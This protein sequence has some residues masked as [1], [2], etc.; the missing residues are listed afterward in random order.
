MSWQLEAW[1][2]SYINIILKVDLAIGAVNQYLSK[3]SDSKLESV[4]QRV[5]SFWKNLVN[6]VLKTNKIPRIQFVG[7]ADRSIS[8]RGRLGM[9][10]KELFVQALI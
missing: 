3:L 2:S 10:E 8:P 6:S 9:T 5:L 1:L 7:Q 4:P